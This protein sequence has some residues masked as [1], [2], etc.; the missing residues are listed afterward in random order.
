M[1]IHLDVVFTG[2]EEFVDLREPS[3]DVPE[4]DQAEGRS[5]THHAN[6]LVLVDPLVA[7]G[8]QQFVCTEASIDKTI[9]E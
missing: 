5:C 4:Q 6:P 7:I 8:N 2:I 9:D 3:L 1:Y